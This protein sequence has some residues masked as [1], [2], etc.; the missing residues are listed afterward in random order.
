MARK[1]KFNINDTELES[2]IVKVDRAKL[3]GSTKKNC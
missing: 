1:V 2:G 3:Y